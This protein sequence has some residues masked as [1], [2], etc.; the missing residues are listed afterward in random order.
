MY[1]PF[2]LVFYFFHKSHTGEDTQDT[3]ARVPAKEYTFH[4]PKKFMYLCFFLSVIHTCTYLS[5]VLYTI[6][7][8][9]KFINNIH[10]ISFMFSIRRD[11]WQKRTT[12]CSTQKLCTMGAFIYT[13]LK[14]K[15]VLVTHCTNISM[16][17]LQS[18]LFT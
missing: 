16:I 12:I 3:H 6:S 9:R 17:N 2:L 1:L 5:V 15:Y 11:R 7:R 18:V 4:I 10:G 8:N 14:K 13:K